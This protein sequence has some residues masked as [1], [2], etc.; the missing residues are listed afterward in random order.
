[1]RVALLAQRLLVRGLLLASAV[2]LFAP[3]GWT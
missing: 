3:S 2:L 1:M